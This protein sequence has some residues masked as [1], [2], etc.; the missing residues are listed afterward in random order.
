MGI[1]FDIGIQYAVLC[2]LMLV[3]PAME[4]SHIVKHGLQIAHSQWS[5][6]EVA[7][8]S[9]WRELCGVLRVVESLATKLKDE[10]LKWLS[11]TKAL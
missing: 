7:Q 11:K 5:Q 6:E 2:I 9:T 1:I 3:P 4:A 10:R 8:S